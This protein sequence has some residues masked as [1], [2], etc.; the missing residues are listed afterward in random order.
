METEGLP[1]DD[2]VPLINKKGKSSAS[3]PTSTTL[4]RLFMDLHNELTDEQKDLSRIL[5]KLDAIQTVA[6]TTC[7]SATR[8]HFSRM[9][10][11]APASAKRQRDWSV[12]SVLLIVAALTVANPTEDDAIF[13]WLVVLIITSAT[14]DTLDQKLSVQVDGKFH[15]DLFWFKHV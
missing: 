9:W 5:R 2:S 13:A 3:L 8:K 14:S 10:S 11:K 4:E 6:V 15:P 7:P 1:V 12:S